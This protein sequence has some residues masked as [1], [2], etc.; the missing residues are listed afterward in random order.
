MVK[1]TDDE[2][3][4]YFRLSDDTYFRLRLLQVLEQLAIAH[5]CYQDNDTPCDC[6]CNETCED[7]NAGG[8]FYKSDNEADAAIAKKYGVDKKHIVEFKS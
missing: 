4:E 2:L 5:G 3:N 6:G 8:V 1:L 7:N